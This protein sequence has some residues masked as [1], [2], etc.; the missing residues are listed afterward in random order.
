MAK[1]VKSSRPEDVELFAFVLRREVQVTCAV[2][3]IL[4]F[5]ETS[6][7]QVFQS[8]LPSGKNTCA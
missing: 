1:P 3:S 5:L 8:N 4:Q 7:P 2:D 6:I